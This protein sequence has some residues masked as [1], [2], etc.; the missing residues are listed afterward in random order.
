MLK[1]EQIENMRLYIL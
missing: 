1:K